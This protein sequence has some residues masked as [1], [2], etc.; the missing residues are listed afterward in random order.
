M[1]EGSSRH[2]RKHRVNVPQ[3]EQLFRLLLSEG[4]GSRLGFFE[5]HLSNHASCIIDNDEAGFGADASGRGTLL[6]P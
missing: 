4:L 3:T 2:Q 5:A 1:S 6:E